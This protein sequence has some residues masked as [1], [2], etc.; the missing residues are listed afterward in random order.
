[1]NSMHHVLRRLDLNLLPIFDAVFRHRSVRLAA[2]EL[3]MSTSALS[4]ALTRLRDLLK[5]PLFYREG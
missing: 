3:S 5:D 1:M 2:A 4:H